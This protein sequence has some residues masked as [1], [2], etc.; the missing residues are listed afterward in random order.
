MS[1]L[2]HIQNNKQNLEIR[3]EIFKLIREFFW[4]EGFIESDTPNLLRLPGQEP[5][6]SP[7]KVLVHDEFGKEFPCFLHTSPE[8]AMKKLLAGGFDKIFNLCK[9]YRDYESFGGTHNPEFSMIEWYRANADFYSIMDDME[10]LFRF[11]AEKLTGRIDPEIAAFVSQQWERKH[12]RDLWREFVN[13]DLDEY[14]TTEKMY[15]LCVQKGYN[16]KAD[17]A[18]EELFYR[19]FL[20]EIEPKLGADA[21]IIVHHYPLQMA[22]LSK[23]SSKDIGYAER[24]EV[25]SKGLELANAFTELTD[26]DEQLR[27]LKEEREDRALQGKDVYDID[28]E[29]IESLRSMPPAAGIAMGVDRM[30][31]LF[32]EAHNIDNILTIPMSKL[33][34]DN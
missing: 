31:Q 6:L 8:Y 28:L 27:R 20:N 1:H 21:P 19:I 2:I 5:N 26:A 3:Y 22:A 30:V 15:E 12:M 14:L 33:Q 16:A 24:F 4:N 34:K 29:F 32:T 18:Y 17:E 23:A 13:V 9:C 7:M 11:C 10:N 25:Y